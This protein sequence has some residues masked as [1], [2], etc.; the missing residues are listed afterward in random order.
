MYF[1]E[2]WTIPVVWSPSGDR[3][4][5]FGA[6]K[7]AMLK[8]GVRLVLTASNQHERHIRTIRDGVKATLAQIRLEYELPA[9]FYPHLVRS[10]VQA[11]N[12]T[13]NPRLEIWFLTKW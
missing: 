1:E 9:V 2:C 7:G 11:L 10:V 5:N 13:A 6:T 3:K 12:L 8:E 4:T